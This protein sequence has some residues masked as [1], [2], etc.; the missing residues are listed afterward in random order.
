MGRFVRAASATEGGWGWW[1][2]RRRRRKGGREGGREGCKRLA[3]VE[4]GRGGN[5][6]AGET[7]GRDGGTKAGG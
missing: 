5:E 1:R 3:G 7:L 6:T 2:R 4:E